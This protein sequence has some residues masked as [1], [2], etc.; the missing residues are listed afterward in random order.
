[1]ALIRNQWQCLECG[2]LHNLPVTHCVCGKHNAAER[3]TC[4][5]CGRLLVVVKIRE[6]EI[7]QV[8]GSV[9]VT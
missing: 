2:S 1:M 4:V 7:R 3:N 8:G 6:P 9:E 5:K